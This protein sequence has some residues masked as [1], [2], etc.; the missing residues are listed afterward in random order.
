MNEIPQITLSFHHR[1]WWHG[2]GKRFVRP[3]WTHCTPDELLRLFNMIESPWYRQDLR[4]QIAEWMNNPVKTDKF[5]LNRYKK[6]KGPEENFRNLTF[7]QFA[8]ADTFLA[9][10]KSGDNANKFAACLF[11]PEKVKFNDVELSEHAKNFADMPAHFQKA[12]MFNFAAIRSHIYAQYP[13]LFQRQAWESS[14]KQPAPP[15][16]DKM[17]RQLMKDVTDDE[18]LRITGSKMHNVFGKLNQMI[19]D[20]K[21]RPKPKYAPNKR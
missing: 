4:I 20:E 11:L 6:F 1:K 8:Y 13:M 16:W 12:L 19:L 5:I 3:Y 14:S 18:M 15:R 7:G 17:I 10:Y 2:R 9:N 21:T